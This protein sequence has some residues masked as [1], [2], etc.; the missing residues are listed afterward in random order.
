MSH[1]WH[2]PHSYCPSQGF[3]AETSCL[4]LSCLPRSKDSHSCVWTGS[5]CFL[6]SYPL[7]LSLLCFSSWCLLSVVVRE[8]GC[9]GSRFMGKNPLSSDLELQ[10][11]S[12]A[13]PPW[14]PRKT[15]KRAWRAPNGARKPPSPSRLNGE[16][17]DTVET[18]PQL[19]SSLVT[20]CI[21]KSPRSR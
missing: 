3:V 13:Q 12:G 16:C 19:N 9:G 6:P 18:D 15:R 8:Q 21:P 17:L 1:E 5:D 7:L 2:E 10:R 4:Y 14:I 11:V 20:P